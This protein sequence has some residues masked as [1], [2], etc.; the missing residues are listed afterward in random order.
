MEVVIDG[1]LGDGLEDST[2]SRDLAR[3][4][5]FSIPLSSLVELLTSLVFKL[6]IKSDCP[7]MD[8]Q[9]RHPENIFVLQM[10]EGGEASSYGDV[11]AVVLLSEK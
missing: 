11:H 2:G 5:D 7:Q 9:S 6:I 10:L 1:M 4:S 8:S 3:I